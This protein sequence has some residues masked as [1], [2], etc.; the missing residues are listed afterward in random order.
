[1]GDNGPGGTLS[2]LSRVIPDKTAHLWL[3]SLPEGLRKG[4]NELAACKTMR[5]K[6]GLTE[7]MQKR[8]IS[9]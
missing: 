7:F 5:D 8:R 4:F 3:T 9:C 2:L 1:M 6:T